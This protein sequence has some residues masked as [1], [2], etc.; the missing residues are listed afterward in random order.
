MINIIALHIALLGLMV[1]GNFTTPDPFQGSNCMIKADACP[2]YRYAENYFKFIKFSILNPPKDGKVEQTI[3]NIE[4][5]AKRLGLNSEKIFE[6]LAYKMSI[7]RDYFYQKMHKDKNYIPALLRLSTAGVVASILAYYKYNNIPIGYWWFHNSL[8][9]LIETIEGSKLW[10]EES[11]TVFG[12][13][14][15]GEI[16]QQ[17]EQKAKLSQAVLQEA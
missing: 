4:N 3:Q 6:Y 10:K 1:A 15:C 7:H 12:Y 5:E 17:Y 2:E 8:I 13:Q 16:Q 9:I 14:A 11:D